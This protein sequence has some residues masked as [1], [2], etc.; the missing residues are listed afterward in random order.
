MG[1]KNIINDIKKALKNNI[2][3]LLYFSIGIAL[4]SALH[5]E[6]HQRAYP[7]CNYC[8][9]HE[10]WLPLIIG[11][12]AFVSLLLVIISKDNFTFKNRIIWQ[13]FWPIFIPTLLIHPKPLPLWIISSSSLFIFVGLIGL[14]TSLN[15]L[16]NENVIQKAIIKNFQ[17]SIILFTTLLIVLGS[18]L[19]Y[20]TQLIFNA[21]P[22][23]STAYIISKYGVEYIIIS[24]SYIGF[25]FILFNLGKVLIIKVEKLAK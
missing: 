13:L 23:L 12:F 9:T 21:D 20:F 24:D 25:G 6:F 17:S 11:I 8:F 5:T 4:T 14:I 7:S 22:D 18:G 3:I 2:Y 19:Y 16:L 1:G 10:Y 15:L